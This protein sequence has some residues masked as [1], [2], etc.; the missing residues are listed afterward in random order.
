M[1]WMQKDEDLRIDRATRYALQKLSK[2]KAST[3]SPPMI[4]RSY[5]ARPTWANPSAEARTESLYNDFVLD[6]AKADPTRY[7]GFDADGPG[8]VKMNTSVTST[9]TGV[10]QSIRQYTVLTKNRFELLARKWLVITFFFACFISNKANDRL[11]GTHS[12][13]FI[14]PLLDMNALELPKSSEGQEQ[15]TAVI[16]PVHSITAGHINSLS[17]SI[18]NQQR[19]QKQLAVDTSEARSTRSAMSDLS[20]SSINNTGTVDE[21]KTA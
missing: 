15:A 12:I 9:L 5:E 8:L 16:L 7:V 13:S 3:D 18:K 4:R 11:Q 20:K 19:R 14:F 6:A 1:N 2:T 21:M 17:L 10:T